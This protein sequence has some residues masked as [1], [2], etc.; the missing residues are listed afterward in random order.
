MEKKYNEK[1]A[2]RATQCVF[3]NA[4]KARKLNRG[5]SHDI[6]EVETNEYPEKVI[7][8]FS[9]DN[10]EKF[11]LKKEVRVN[12]IIQKLG[13]PVPRIILHD[14][15]KET[16]PYEFV[17]M[18]KLEGEDL[19]KI[20][21]NLSIKEQLEI[22]E[23][24]GEI[25][26]RIH[27]IKFDR[28][29]M[30]L[31]EGI[32][33]EGSF[34]LKGNKQ[35]INSSPSVFHI[36]SM[37]LDD[38]GRFAS[39]NNIN[40]EFSSH[41][42][43]FIIKNKKLAESNEEPCL[44]HGDFYKSN[45]KVKKIKNKWFIT[46]LLDFEY[47]ASEIKEYDFIKLDREGFLEPGKIRQALL[48]G[49]QKFQKVDE[50]FDKKVKYFRYGRDVGFAQVLL[51]IGRIKLVTEVLENLKQKTSFKGDIFVKK[52]ENNLKKYT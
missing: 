23:K 46:G 5:Y 8:R 3:H 37:A 7:I 20:W 36:L 32:D 25:L 4:S 47:A 33:D 49:Y 21:E 40:P 11:S 38:L 43:N 2:L 51:K 22:I 19:D 24:I 6:Y 28:F 44:I 26:G 15:T 45:F 12:Q 31:P 30:L 27:T 39:Y 41:I 14:E 13:I 50:G 16:V 52:I 17:I 10:P 42:A 9:N 29:G 48:K 1:D 35:K 34:S 18:S